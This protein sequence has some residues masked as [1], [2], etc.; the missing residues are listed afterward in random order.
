[1]KG[2]I[3]VFCAFSI[4]QSSKLLPHAELQVEHPPY[5]EHIGDIGQVDFVTIEGELRKSNLEENMEKAHNFWKENL[6]TAVEEE[7]NHQALPDCDHCF[8]TAQELI[9]RKDEYLSLWNENSKKMAILNDWYSGKNNNKHTVS[10]YGKMNNKVDMTYKSTFEWKTFNPP[11]GNV[12]DQLKQ[13][14]RVAGEFK[15][16]ISVREQI[17]FSAIEGKFNPNVIKYFNVEEALKKKNLSINV[18]ESSHQQLQFVGTGNAIKLILKVKTLKNIMQLKKLIVPPMKIAGTSNYVLIRAQGLEEFI[19]INHE[20]FAHIPDRYSTFDKSSLKDNCDLVG[21]LYECKE[22]SFEMRKDTH[23]CVS[24]FYHKNV[25]KVIHYC[26]IFVETKDFWEVLEDQLYI[27][28]E[29]IKQIQLKCQNTKEVDHDLEPS[30]NVFK[31]PRDCDIIINEDV[32]IVQSEP[33]YHVQNKA[34]PFYKTNTFVTSLG[35][36]IRRKF[37]SIKGTLNLPSKTLIANI[38]EK[39]EWYDIVLT[40][41]VT[42]WLVL[43]FIIIAMFVSLCLIKKLKRYINQVVTK[44][45]R[46][47][48]VMQQ[49]EFELL[50]TKVEE[51]LKFAA[52]WKKD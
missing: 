4:V 32:T 36:E 1:M 33:D 25:E 28:S 11:K 10:K 51:G 31:V 21:S 43:V 5:L 2:L 47:Q 9:A 17:F 49:E 24:A 52:N 6:K 22:I 48:A 40:F 15:N 26:D 7:I 37:P 50:K 20:P 46:S 23:S 34:E 16:E 12:L 18:W 39:H 35:M 38:T 29:E 42:N 8:T 44:S 41:I 13:L 45:I 19:A 27:K 14:I 30:L 3:L